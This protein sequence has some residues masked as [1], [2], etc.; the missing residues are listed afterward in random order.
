MYKTNIVKLNELKLNE[1]FIEF[2]ST[3]CILLQR[4]KYQSNSNIYFVYSSNSI[5]QKM[6]RKVIIG[7]VG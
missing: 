6:I 2:F 4:R 7:H 5:K 1:L 3:R